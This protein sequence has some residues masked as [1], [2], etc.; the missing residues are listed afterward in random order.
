MAKTRPPQGPPARQGLNREQL[1]RGA[2]V[3]APAA[4]RAAAPLAAAGGRGGRR[5]A[6]IGKFYR[7]TASELRKV[8][9]PSANQTRDLTLAVLA[10]SIGVGLFL[11]AFDFIFQELFRWL[12]SLTG[13]T[14]L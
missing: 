9:W 1:R 14:G 12:L 5:N 6:S 10:L 2:G 4:G 13:N 7:E 8:A 3:T 11:G